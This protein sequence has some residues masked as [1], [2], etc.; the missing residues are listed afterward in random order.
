MTKSLPSPEA[1]I[2]YGQ[3]GK[4]VEGRM[5]AG[6]TRLA[7]SNRLRDLGDECAMFG[8]EASCVR[9]VAGDHGRVGIERLDVFSFQEL[10][11]RIEFL[12]V[13]LLGLR[14]LLYPRPVYKVEFSGEEIC[15]LVTRRNASVRKDEIEIEVIPAIRHVAQRLSSEFTPLK[16]KHM[17]VSVAV[18]AANVELLSLFHGLRLLEGGLLGEVHGRTALEVAGSADRLNFE[19]LV[20]VPVVVLNRGLAAV[21]AEEAGRPGQ[22]TRLD[23]GGH[24]QVGSVLN[25]Q[26][27]RDGVAGEAQKASRATAPLFN[28]AAPRALAAEETAG[29]ASHSGP[30]LLARLREFGPNEL[31]VLR[32][33]ITTADRSVRGLLDSYAPINGNEISSLPVADDLDFDAKQRG[34]PGQTSHG[35]CG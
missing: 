16:Q 25:A 15:A 18:N 13:A 7:V 34:E 14:F 32:A 9:F 29:L 27:P 2:L 17:P 28:G 4:T 12:G 20:V 8:V 22:L 26:P 3:A 5:G 31:P 33:Q 6:F 21:S 30:R 35:V 1:V 19:R 11:G 10:I 23:G 24:G